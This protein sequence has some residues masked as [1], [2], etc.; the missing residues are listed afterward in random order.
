MQSIIK[1]CVRYWGNPYNCC[2]QTL[3]FKAK[4]HQV[5]FR[6]GL[7][8]TPLGKLTALPKS[9]TSISGAYTKERQE[10]KKDKEKKLQLNCSSFD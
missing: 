3:S 1:Y 2:H 10:T 4:M 8:Q 5:W 6:L 9:S 7:P